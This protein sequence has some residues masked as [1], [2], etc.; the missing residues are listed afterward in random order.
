MAKSPKRHR[1]SWSEAELANLRKMTPQN[2]AA[3]IA[4]VLE[5]SAAAV[6]NMATLIGS[7]FAPA[8]KPAAKKAAAKKPVAK[9]A[10]VKKAT[11]KKTTKSAATAN[12]QLRK[13]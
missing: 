13:R 10:P 9:K 3:A 7:P 4:T 1:E 8:K 11:A 2:T 12:R 6:R 5:R